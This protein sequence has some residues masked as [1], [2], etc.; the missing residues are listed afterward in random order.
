[1]T[2]VTSVVVALLC[3]LGQVTGM[4][5]RSCGVD[6]RPHMD[7]ICGQSL[8]RARNN[9][10]F[11]LYADYPDHFGKRSVDDIFNYPVDAF[12]KMNMLGYG[13]L[14]YTSP[15]PR[16]ISLSRMPSSA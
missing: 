3:M 15:S 6:A 7:G 9:L 5:R 12:A 13:C 8:V 1:M 4:P 16:D 11:L 14:L 10:C 2:E